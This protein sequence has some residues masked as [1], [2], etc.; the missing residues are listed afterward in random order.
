MDLSPAE[1]VFIANASLMEKLLFSITKWDWHLLDEIIESGADDIEYNNIEKEKVRAVTKVLLIP[2]KSETNI[3]K[4]RLA[5]GSTDDPF[6]ALVLSHEDRVASNVRLLHSAFSFI[7]QIR[8]PP[9]DADCPDRH[10]AYRKV[11]ELHNPWIK[12]LLLG[13]ARTSYANG[14]KKPDAPPH[15]L[16]EEIDNELGLF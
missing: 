12:R 13:F 16:I 10:F 14:P 11:E 9:I 3:L 7:P 1:T 6:K 8:A 5:T 15:H 4:R 2:S